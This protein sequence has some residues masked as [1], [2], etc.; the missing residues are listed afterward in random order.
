MKKLLL[1][2][3]A[4]IQ[5][6]AHADMTL[7]ERVKTLQ[8]LDKL[9]PFQVKKKIRK[10]ERTQEVNPNLPP[11]ID[12]RFRDTPVQQQTAQNCTAY[13][14][15]ASMENLMDGRIK[16]SESDLW[17]K[18][19]VGDID[20]ALKFASKSVALE[21]GTGNYHLVS[22]EDIGTDIN[23]AKEALTNGNVVYLGFQVTQ[24][25]VNCEARPSIDSPLIE[26]GGHAVEVVGYQDDRFIIKNSWGAQCGDSGYQYIPFQ[27]CIKNK[28]CVMYEIKS[29]SEN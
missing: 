26:E 29:V 4:L 3:V 1:V 11:S 24:D 6:I 9:F 20:T 19:E 22:Y 14:L 2:G 28:M 18:Y 16:L 23:K 10:Q 15:V 5:T 7:S 25:V 21:D 13:G 12:L 27:Y 8:P 17:S